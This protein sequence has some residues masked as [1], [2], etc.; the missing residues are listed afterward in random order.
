MIKGE[1]TLDWLSLN[2]YLN[3]LI[4]YIMIF[5]HPIRQLDSGGF[6]LFEEIGVN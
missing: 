1:S 6:G 3:D 5:C 2:Y 4:S